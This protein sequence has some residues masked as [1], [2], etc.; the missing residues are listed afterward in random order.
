V[1]WRGGERGC[2]KVKDV[3][4]C[5]VSLTLYLNSVRWS[6]NYGGWGGNAILQRCHPSNGSTL[7]SGYDEAYPRTCLCLFIASAHTFRKRAA[8]KSETSGTLSVAAFSAAE[9]SGMAMKQV[10]PTAGASMARLTPVLPAVPS[11]IRPP[12]RVERS[13]FFINGLD[14]EIYCRTLE[15]S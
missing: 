4:M 11:V 9:S 5:C 7:K 13:Q 2:G 6:V 1:G 8:R 10:Q 3:V 12:A 14:F 15:L